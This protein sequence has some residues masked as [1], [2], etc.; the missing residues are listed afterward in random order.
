MAK[1]KVDGKE[2]TV[3]D[4]YTLLQAA[5]DAGA[6]VPRFCFHERLSIAGNC[7]MCLI[8][9]KGGPPKPQA[10]C[11]MGVRDLRP[12]PNGETPEIFTNTP[13]VKKAREGVMEFL[14]INH[15]LDCPICDQGGECDL[16]DQAMAFGVDSSRYHEN[17]RAV[18]DKYIGP[19]VKT[20]MNR[21]IHCTRCVRFTTEIAGI[22]ELGLIGRGEDAEITT[23]LESAMTSELQGN[24]IDLCPVGALTSK[25]YA[26]QARP[27]ELT[28]T[29]S[30]DVMDAVGSAI[31]VDSR[32]REVMRILPRTN[33]A[34]N[35]EW[36][37]D[38]TRFIW[39]GLRTQRLD[40]PYVRKN[41]KLA[42]ASW[43][44]A[45]SAIKEAVSRT[46]PDK[47]GA[48]SGDLAAVEEIYA[49]KLL[50]ASLGSKN[51]DCRQDG[52]ALDP[53][54]GRASYLFNPTIEGIEQAD[55]VLIIGAN[56][57]FEAS[58]L[59]ARIRK[60]WRLGNLPVGVIGDVG[61]TR[62]DYEQLGAGPESLKDLA[63]G[64]G[65]FFQVL[66]QATHPL[67]IVGQGALSRSD[68]AAVLGQAAKLS[69]A[70]NAARAD[71]NGFAV[72]HTAAARVG[73]LDVGFVPGEGG[74]NVAGMLGDMEVLFLLGA[75]EIDMT[76]T[77]GAFV[78]YIGTHGDHGAHRADVILPGAA[79]TEKSGTYVNTEG[80]VQQTNRAGFAPGDAREDW[81]I[82]RALSDV[83]GKRLSF[84]SLP[85][86]RAKLYGEYPHLARI[87]QVAAGN[88]DDIAKVAKLGGRLGKGAFT[89]PVKDFYLT[90]P[91]ARAS[92]V[93]AECSALAKNGFRQAAE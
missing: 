41:G 47:I 9:V 2:I 36:I 3:P 64:N 69:L 30:I 78:V 84:D 44:E 90:N 14:L 22:S 86:L 31:R 53:S 75:D 89:S 74:K 37:S 29:E 24:V 16:Q 43:A 67:V 66:K 80:R 81:A 49:L 13:M 27:W 7:R 46:A 61:D 70:V 76:R 52:A 79:Y 11:A 68:G 5:E 92:A 83:L 28:K 42:P 59:N 15:P 32:G 54:L 35:E 91:I 8:E 48:I 20:I 71:W 18:E 88:A 1:L 77:G 45:F 51:T 93:M 19:L 12:G 72:L 65:K 58:L 60:R 17:K 38:K 62:Y 39:D 63:D 23:Y 26:F 85:H 25:P 57:R 6:E 73:G 82:L 50:M 4:H 56:P 40:R 55:A 33:E 21:C 87:D 34:V 10:S